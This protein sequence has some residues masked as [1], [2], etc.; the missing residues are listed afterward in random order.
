MAVAVVMTKIQNSQQSGGS[1]NF[2]LLVFNCGDD[3][4]F[5]RGDF[6]V[7][8]RLQETVGEVNRVATLFLIQVTVKVK[9]VG[10][11][12]YSLE[13]YLHIGSFFIVGIE[14]RKI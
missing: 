8:N 10:P 9:G 12:P 6:H 4:R 14:Y 5:D 1:E 11:V 13:I 7:G 3:P 2:K